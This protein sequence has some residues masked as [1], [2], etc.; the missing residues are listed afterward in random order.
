MFLAQKVLSH[1]GASFGLL[2]VFLF[3]FVVD[4]TAPLLML[5]AENVELDVD[6]HSNS[7]SS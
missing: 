3:F 6:C 2:P 7:R 4:V 5:N 1:R